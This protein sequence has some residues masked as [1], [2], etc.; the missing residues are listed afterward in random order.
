MESLKNTHMIIL[1]IISKN[2][3]VSKIMDRIKNKDQN[4]FVF[5]DELDEVLLKFFL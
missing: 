2:N 5:W 4:D 3:E 1:I